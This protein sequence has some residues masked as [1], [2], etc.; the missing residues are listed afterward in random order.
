MKIYSPWIAAGLLAF[1][2]AAHASNISFSTFVGSAPIAS[3]T[4]SNST[5]AITYAG[6]KFVGSTYFDNQLYS[7][8][9]TGGG[10]AA[11]G[12]ALP[13]SSGSVGEIVLGASLGLGGFANGNI[14]AGSQ[15]DTKIFQYAN[16]GGA[17]SLFATLPPAAGDVRQILFDPGATFGGNMIVS[18][19][20]GNI[21]TVSSA[22]VVTP[23]VNIG[24][25]TEGMDIAPASFGPYAGQLLVGSEGTGTLHLVSSTGVVTV[26]GTAG[27]FPGSETVSV[28]PTGLDASN[29]LQ[30]FYVANYSTDIQVA[31]AA[32]F[33]TEGL[34]GSVIVTDETGGSTAWDVTYSGGAFVSTPFTFTGHSISQFEDGI[35]VSP[36]RIADVTPPSGPAP[37]P[38]S[39]VMLG[40]GLL[41]LCGAVKRKLTA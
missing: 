29:P 12:T 17:A 26:V 14:F 41:G 28:I 13:E 3:A 37:E 7:T 6:N 38:S 15:A 35:F 2:A 4:G 25:D 30:G 10:V 36:Q 9:L 18:T 21:Y 31:T 33:I 22:G 23:L 11:F 20:T 16:S 27:Q 24:A 32:Q 8:N 39:L 19:N 40:T 5:I 34:Q 1:S